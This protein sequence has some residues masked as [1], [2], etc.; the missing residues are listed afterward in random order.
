MKKFEG[1]ACVTEDSAELVQLEMTATD[2]ISMAWGLVGRLS[3]GSRVTYER[4][5]VQGL[6]LPAR[7]RIEARGRTLLFR[8]FDVDSLTEW[9]DYRP[10]EATGG[11]S[12]SETR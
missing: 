8:S 12:T 6:W 3:K 9:F 7:A 11:E 2:T 1:V 5:P 4:R 10:H